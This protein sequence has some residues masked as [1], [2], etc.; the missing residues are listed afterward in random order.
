MRPTIHWYEKTNGGDTSRM[1]L[2]LTWG[3][4]VIGDDGASRRFRSLIPSPLAPAPQPNTASHARLHLDVPY[5]KNRR[6][7]QGSIIRP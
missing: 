2:R 5:M 3:T 1:A 7:E 4:R 6:R